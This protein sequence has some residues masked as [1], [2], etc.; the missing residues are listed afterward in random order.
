MAFSTT[1]QHT[2]GMSANRIN[3]RVL[4]GMKEICAYV[5]RSDETVRKYIREEGFPA[6]KEG[7]SLIAC[8]EHIDA[9]RLRRLGP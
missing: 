8:A 1:D 3:P 2:S 5:G 7:G 9:W 6:G 4:R